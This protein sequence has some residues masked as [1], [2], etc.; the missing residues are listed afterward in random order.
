MPSPPPLWVFPVVPLGPLRPTSR[1]AAVLTLA[2]TLALTVACGDE[3]PGDGLPATDLELPRTAG[4]L[5]AI[6]ALPAL[7]ELPGER[8]SVLQPGGPTGCS[9]GTDFAFL[10]WPGRSDRLVVNFIG[11]G[12]CWDPLTCGLQ[13]FEPTV[14]RVLGALEAGLL[15]GIFDMEN[16]ENPVA[17]RTHVVVPYCTA[18]VHWGDQVE[19]YTEE[20]EVDHR[21]ATNDRVVLGWV[22]RHLPAPERVLTTG[23]SAG[24]YGSSLWG[25]HLMGV[26]PEASHVLLA[27]ASVGVITDDFF[28]DS[29]PRWNATAAF[30]D[31]IPGFDPDRVTGA[32]DYWNAFAAHFP[33][34]TFAQ[35]TAVRDNNQ[36]LFYELMGGEGG[37]DGWSTRMRGTLDAIA[38][39]SPN[40]RWF[41]AG[42]DPDTPELPEDDVH[43]ILN[44]DPKYFDF[45]TG[46][47]LAAGSGDTFYELD[48]AGTRFLD[49]LSGLLDPEAD[50]GSVACPGCAPAG[51]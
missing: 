9:L 23:C 18:D 4:E 31:F 10:V 50:P 43:C 38:E 13:T 12:A 5:Q 21:G 30:P 11:G 28:V 15:P 33:D 51:D 25:A 8:W 19:R 24:G 41:V 3:D 35:F 34:A 17:D 2:A 20:L 22:E 49:W 29:F 46:D 40:F 47:E 27:D 48:T 42:D 26:F 6:E 16:P 45:A 44:P 32:P 1:G 14:D 39:A 37:A 36:V 7:D